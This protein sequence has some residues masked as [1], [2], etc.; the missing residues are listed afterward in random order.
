M[1]IDIGIERGLSDIKNF[2]DI[3]IQPTLIFT[4]WKLA[5]SSL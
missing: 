2:C 4:R 1:L 3:S 5:A